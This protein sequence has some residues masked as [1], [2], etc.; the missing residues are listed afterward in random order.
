[1]SHNSRIDYGDHETEAEQEESRK[2][3][4]I[5]N[6]SVPIGERTRYVS[7][8]HAIPLA[9]TLMLLLLLLLMMMMM[10]MMMMV[11]TSLPSAC[12]CFYSY[13]P[14]FNHYSVCLSRSLDVFSRDW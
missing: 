7:P 12:R 8:I 14:H 4:P 9:T 10:M 3:H 1:M 11:L 6:E 2:T 13:T 5:A